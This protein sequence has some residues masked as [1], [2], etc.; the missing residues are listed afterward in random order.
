MDP[1]I[2]KSKK[3]SLTLVVSTPAM[4]KGQKEN[5]KVILAKRRINLNNEKKRI[6]K[7][8]SDE[9]NEKN[10]KRMGYVLIKNKWTPKLSKKTGEKSISKERTP[11]E[12]G[13][14]RNH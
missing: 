11:P 6:P 5:L 8:I 1:K 9:Y 7:A 13:V 10:L 12:V 4:A 14:P 2:A 3:P